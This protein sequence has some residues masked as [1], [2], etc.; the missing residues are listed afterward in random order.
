MNVGGATDELSI[1]LFVDIAFLG[2]T[3]SDMGL[4]CVLSTAKEGGLLVKS[5]GYGIACQLNN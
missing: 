4:S 3:R 2:N 1:K 5:V